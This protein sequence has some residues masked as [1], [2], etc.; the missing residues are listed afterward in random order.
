MQ[1]LEISGRRQLSGC[2]LRQ[3]DLLSRGVRSEIDEREHIVDRWVP[4]DWDR[5]LGHRGR[6]PRRLQARLRLAAHRHMLFD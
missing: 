3:R 4:Q 6:S 5:A 2:D 1:D